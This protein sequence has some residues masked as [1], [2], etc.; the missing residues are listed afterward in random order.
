MMGQAPKRICG[1]WVAAVAVLGLSLQPASAFCVRNDTG[2]PIRIE[3]LDDSAAFATEVGNNKKACC[4]PKD[5][6]CAIGGADIKLSIHGSSGD[7]AC[8]VTV[9]PK[10]NVNVTGDRNTL[11]CKANKAGS[12]MDWAS[13]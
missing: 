8:E 11:K 5:E 4:S 1:G 2:A 7:A 6:S 12:T 13:G 9:D 3:A 10:G